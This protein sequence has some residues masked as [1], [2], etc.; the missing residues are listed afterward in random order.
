MYRYLA[1]LSLVFMLCA[2][3]IRTQGQTVSPPS[4]LNFQGR[5]AKSNGTPVANGTYSIQFSLYDALTSGTQKWTQTVSGV[6]VTN[7]TFAVLLSG[8]PATT[9]DGNLWLEIKVGS[10][11]A[12]TPRQQLV[13]VAYAMK[14]NTVPDG[15]IT[16]AK[17][18]DGA[19]TS[20]KLST[21]FLTAGGDLM[22]T[23]P[24]PSLITNSSLLNK[25]SG[26]RV[27]IEGDSVTVNSPNAITL[28]LNTNNPNSLIVLQKNRNSL[29]EFGTTTEGSFYLG[30]ME[31]AVMLLQRSTGNVGI[32]VV[33]PR[34]KLDVNGDMMV[35]NII[36]SGSDFVLKGRGG[37]VG[38]N[39][40]AGRAMVD[41]GGDGLYLNYA[42]DFGRVV[43]DSDAI[44]R[45]TISAT[46]LQATGSDVA[47]PYNISATAN[48]L[49]SS[50]MVVSIKR[51]SAGKLQVSGSAYDRTVAGIISGANG[52][53][54]G[55]VLRQ[56][57][58]LADGNIPVASSGRVYCWCNADANGAIEE[59]D[60]LTTSNT[61]GHAMKA[62]DRDRRDGAVLGK[63]MSTLTK[64]KGLVLVLVTLQ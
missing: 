33:N 44:V 27:G 20:S 2:G 41:L 23:F 34:A 39:G 25:V 14:A 49:P 60:L 55:L 7:G 18:A 17:L 54:P 11:V 26:G 40:N 62:T 56:P 32:G 53:K 35:N 21:N 30:N 43:I 31:Y 15:A 28:R 16:T 52:V 8:F 51:G 45:G 38:N 59:G 64:G 29:W 3:P 4:L 24:N 12:L 36:S 47:E 46:E 22:G 9:F 58:T 50:G 13:S 61:P 1:M 19:I 48:V 63:A 5:L 42:N 57:G 6:N 37:G 10:N